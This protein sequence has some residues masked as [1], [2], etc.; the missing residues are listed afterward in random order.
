MVMVQFLQKNLKGNIETGC[1]SDAYCILDARKNLT[2]LIND[3]EKIMQK[4]Q[5]HEFIGFVIKKGYDFNWCLNN[6]STV[7]YSTHDINTIMYLN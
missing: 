3:A 4:R 7:I 6:K 1:A 5:L 2:N